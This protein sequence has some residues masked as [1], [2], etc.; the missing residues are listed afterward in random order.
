MPR[1]TLYIAWIFLLFMMHLTSCTAGFTP[2][3]TYKPVDRFF[4]DGEAAFQNR[5][6]GEALRAYQAFLEVGAEDPRLPQV[7]LK[8]GETYYAVN[9]YNQ[10]QIYLNRL[11][12]EFPESDKA[13]Q[14]ELLLSRIEYKKG[15]TDGAL[16]MLRSL[17][18]ESPRRDVVVVSY[19]LRGRIFMEQGDLELGFSQ[20]KKS[21]ML[22]GEG[23]ESLPLYEEMVK[24]MDVSI[25]DEELAKIARETP[26]AFPGDVSMFLMGKRAWDNGEPIRASQLFE[27]FY[28]LFPGH[29]LTKKARQ[30]REQ[31][32]NLQSLSRVS[33]G[34]ILPLSGPLKEIGTQVLQGIH[35]SVDKLN[36]MFLEE[37]VTLVV[38]DCGGDPARA[39]RQMEMFA[40]DPGIVAVI[41][42]VISRSV[43][44]TAMIAEDAQLAMITPTATAEGIGE[45]GHYIFR[46]AM[47]NEAQAKTMAHYA[48]LQLDLHTM[49]ILYPDDYYG[50]ELHDLFVDEFTT[51]GGEVLLSV[52]YKRGSVD[53]GPQIRR[54]I[55]T[56]IEGI[57]FRNTEMIQMGD[58]SMEEWIENYYP[59]FDAVYLPGYAE[60]VGLI[61]PQLAYYNIEAV[62]L[63]GSHNWNSMELIRRGERFIEG[64]VFTD[65]FFV[66]SSHTDITEFVAQYRKVYG[67]EPTLFSAQAYDAAEMILQV[68]YRGGRSRADIQ[69]GLLSQQNFPGVS[70]LTTVLPT[71]E[72]EKELFLIRVVDGSFQQIN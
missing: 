65:G 61:I 59:S 57:L 63:L 62:Q 20:W 51:L 56:D 8:L 13:D 2:L 40:R 6:Y 55:Q 10:S 53:Y 16:A 5:Q 24:T 64:A 70:G 58:Y 67:E 19:L 68:L 31:E 15:N 30:Y 43:V 7:M 1:R 26:R 48:A 9:D 35:L 21:L 27:K 46:N 23:E 17:V 3:K 49:A 18:R 14:A 25:P 54:I 60:D 11:L 32:T 71:G 72:M 69:N 4:M 50:T 47:T 34:C 42:P 66:G 12:A 28:V 29:A 44:E 33:V 38:S 41:G 45:M 39:R 37:K 52:P 36:A 22:V